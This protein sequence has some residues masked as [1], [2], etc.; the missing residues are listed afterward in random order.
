[1]IK[2]YGSIASRIGA[3]LCISHNHITN[4][5]NYVWCISVRFTTINTRFQSHLNRDDTSKHTRSHELNKQQK[6]MRNQK[7]MTCRRT[8][9]EGQTFA[10]SG[11]CCRLVRSAAY[12]DAFPCIPRKLWVKGII[13]CVLGSHVGVSRYSI[14]TT[15]RERAAIAGGWCIKLHI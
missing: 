10:C 3:F 1:M 11:N 7:E 5:K 13:N 9:K 6:R 14:G 15:K 8:T 4:N 2:K 12:S